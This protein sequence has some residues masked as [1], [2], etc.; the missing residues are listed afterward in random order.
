MKCQFC[1]IENLIAKG[2]H[3]NHEYRCKLNPNRITQNGN[4]GKSSW[5]RGLTKETDSRI[6]SQASKLRGRKLPKNYHSI[7]ARQKL[8]RLAKERKL[9]GYRPHPNKGEWYRGIYFDSKWE[10][11]VAKSLDENNIEWE[12][13]KIGFVWTD[14]GKKYY[15]DFFLPQFNIF[16]DPKNSFLRKKDSLK[17]EES[18]KRNGIRVIVL[19]EFQLNWSEIYAAII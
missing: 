14:C 8:S 7:E 12:R 5:S 3:K 11:A 4:R 9:G 16:L 6:E 13:P 1:G 19:T 2:A 17:I 15:P 18:Q 10:V